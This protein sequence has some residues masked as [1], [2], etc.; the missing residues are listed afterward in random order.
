MASAVWRPTDPESRSVR[1]GPQ[2]LTS[3]VRIYS[4]GA[5]SRS[6]VERST[7]ID[8]PSAPRQLLAATR[9]LVRSTQ[10]PMLTRWWARAELVPLHARWHHSCA[11]HP[12]SPCPRAGFAF[13]TAHKAADCAMR[14]RAASGYGATN[15]ASELERFHREKLS[16]VPGNRCVGGKLSRVA[17]QRFPQRHWESACWG[18]A[19]QDYCDIANIATMLLDAT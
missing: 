11:G 13:Q 12:P 5:M 10:G 18:L 8:Q 9:A 14:L 7:C 1:G 15:L 19:D 6:N 2:H 16:G 3:R 17:A 4:H